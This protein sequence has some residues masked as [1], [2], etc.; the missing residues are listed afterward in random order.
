MDIAAVVNQILMMLLIMG[1]GLLL[2]RAGVLTAEVIKGISGIVLKVAMPCLVLMMVQRDGG[3]DLRADFLRIALASLLWMSAG[4]LI[5]YVVFRKK[6]PKQRAAVFAGLCAL[7]NVGYMGMPIVS[8]VYGDLGVVYLAAAVVGFNCTIYLTLEIMMTGRLPR[9]SALARNIGLILSLLAL[10]TF[11]L[12]I[13]IPM[14]L[15]VDTPAPPKNTM[16]SL[17]IIISRNLSGI[18][19]PPFIP[20]QNFKRMP[21]RAF[22][23]IK[24]FVDIRVAQKEDK[25]KPPR[26]ISGSLSFERAIIGPV[27]P[28]HKAS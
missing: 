13:R 20:V 24:T 4:L 19:K 10:A 17:P 7:P 8:A 15:S 25:N 6:L 26:V 18:L 3:Q 2:R 27:S 12:G 11:M 22:G 1:A 14:P 23:W 9:P 16:L 28:F 21:G 5:V